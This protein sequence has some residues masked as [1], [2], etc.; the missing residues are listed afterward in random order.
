MIIEA[1]PSMYIKDQS[2]SDEVQA[3]IDA[4]GVINGGELN[5]AVTVGFNGGKSDKVKAK[6]QSVSYSKGFIERSSVQRPVLQA[7]KQASKSPHPWRDLVD[8]LRVKVSVTHL[9]R[10]EVGTTTFGDTETWKAVE[11]VA[12]EMTREFNS[13]EIN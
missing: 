9:R 2:L 5:K 3:W 12:T 13:D 10:V 1:T 11:K 7:Y 4:G 6:K 8:R